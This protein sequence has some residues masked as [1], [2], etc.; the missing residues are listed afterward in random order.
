MAVIV[1][2]AAAT[3]GIAL[4]YSGLTWFQMV[5]PIFI[6]SLAGLLAAFLVEPSWRDKTARLCF[7]VAQEVAATKS[8]N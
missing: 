1:S 2:P 8:R 7:N 4:K 5:G 3:V 6:L